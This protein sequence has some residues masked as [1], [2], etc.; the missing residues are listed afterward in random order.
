MGDVTSAELAQPT[1]P[2]RFSKHWH[3][4]QSVALV[5]ITAVLSGVIPLTLV[6]QVD[7]VGLTDAWV[8]TAAIIVW[9][10]VRLGW[11]IVAGMPRLFDFFFWMF[12]YIFMG[13]APTVQ[14][15]SGL[16]STTT[17]GIDEGLYLPTALVVCLGLGAYE[18]GRMAW[19]GRE[20]SVPRLTGTEG[21]AMPAVALVDKTHTFLLVG[22]GL[23]ASAYF[24]LS[25]GPGALLGSRAASFAAREGAWPDPAIR[26]VMYALAIY[27]LLVG[28]GAIAQLRRRAQAPTVVRWYTLSLVGCV[29]V[30][31][32]IVNPI[33]SARYT[34]GTVGFALAVYAGALVSAKR[35][36][37]A[38][39][40][41]LGAFLFLFPLADA[42]RSEEVKLTRNGFFGEYMSNPDYD[43]FWQVANAFSY[44]V[45]GLVI[46]LRQLLG[47]V[48][49]WVPRAVW[50]DKP[51][52]TGILLA[53]YRGYSFDNLS[54]PLWAELLVNGGIILVVVGFVLAGIGLRFMDTR[55]LLSF[56][57]GGL[58][59]VVGAIFPVYMTIL[60]RGSLLQATGAMAVAVACVLFIRQRS[61]DER[62]DRA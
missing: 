11:L 38:L 46:P 31:L 10:G 20:R 56:G 14:L 6:A 51:T 53:N 30:L 7:D 34:F 58:W 13:I 43:A 40:S 27:P 41:T 47:S 3:V 36:R 35:V 52:D 21:A 29:V 4:G 28:A 45:D 12:C 57:L 32:L 17:P 37:V 22:L 19:I 15:R 1:A 49:F 25:V 16:T 39:A 60:M 23:A 42:F 2:V 26:S 54:A 18:L 62:L 48:L 50:A 44:S 8:F 24:L 61:N 55:L 9:G 5:A 59:A 33:G